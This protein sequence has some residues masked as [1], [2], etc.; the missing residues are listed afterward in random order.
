MKKKIF[1]YYLKTCNNL[2][3]IEYLSIVNFIFSLSL[4]IKNS[5]FCKNI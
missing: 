5:I 3:N 2:K 1:S 4:I